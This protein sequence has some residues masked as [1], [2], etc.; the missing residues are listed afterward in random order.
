MA[1]P[2]PDPIPPKT[3]RPPRPPSSGPGLTARNLRTAA[4]ALGV[5][6]AAGGVTLVMC[7]GGDEKPERPA[8]ALPPPAATE[9]PA[10]TPSTVTSSAPAPGPAASSALT[11]PTALP[12][13]RVRWRGTMR[14]DG[15]RAEEDLDQAPPRVS[16]RSGEADIR[17]DWLKTQL[18][19][20][21]DARVAVLPP[22]GRPGAA[23]CRDAALA[24]GTAVTQPLREGDVVCVATKPGRVVR[25]ITMHAAQTSGP[26]TLTFSVVV[27]DVSEGT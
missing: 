5:S 2:N 4:I 8:A 14:V 13:P 16:E 26:P 12:S 9:Q 24:S 7:S 25:L 1:M 17:G 20:M 11:S 27:W 18:K 21:S 15:P 10:P 6:L 3:R 19:A 23:Q 22:E